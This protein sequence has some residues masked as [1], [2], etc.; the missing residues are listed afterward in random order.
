MDTHS[1]GGVG[2]WGVAGMVCISGVC[3]ILGLLIPLPHFVC[4]VLHHS[5]MSTQTRAYV[6]V[7]LQGEGK[8]MDFSNSRSSYIYSHM[9]LFGKK[10]NLLTFGFMSEHVYLYNSRMA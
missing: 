1:Y 5:C 6:C 3:C 7:P 8:L 10:H 2:I 4:S 9:I